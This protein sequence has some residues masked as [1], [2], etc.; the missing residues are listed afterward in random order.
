MEVES[1]CAW[2]IRMLFSAR[3]VVTPKFHG[4]RSL[5]LICS[6]VGEAGWKLQLSKWEHAGAEEHLMGKDKPGL[7]RAAS[8]DGSTWCQQDIQVGV[9]IGPEVVKKREITTTLTT[10][11]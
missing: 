9:F 4:E 6:V 11:A 1:R 5:E 10:R 7:T 2:E 3:G 8:I